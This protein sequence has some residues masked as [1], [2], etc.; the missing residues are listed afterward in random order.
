MSKPD[1]EF[2]E[3]KYGF[4]WGA[5]EISRVVSHQG[6]VHIE[7]NTPRQRI[8]VRVTPSGLI[9]QEKL[10]PRKYSHE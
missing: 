5:A 7:I 9:R 3:T 8:M 4:A 2:K 1:P 6:H 10:N